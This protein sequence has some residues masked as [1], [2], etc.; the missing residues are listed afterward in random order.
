MELHPFFTSWRDCYEQRQGNG[1]A[2]IALIYL[3]SLNYAFAR[4]PQLLEKNKNATITLHT[5]P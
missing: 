2:A 3:F 5:T 1:T 4:Y